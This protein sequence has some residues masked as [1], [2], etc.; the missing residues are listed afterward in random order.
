[1]EKSGSAAIPWNRLIKFDFLMNSVL[2]RAGLFFV[3]FS[4]YLSVVENNF[5][6]NQGVI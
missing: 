6:E 3:R 5:Q 1:M 2:L 4:R